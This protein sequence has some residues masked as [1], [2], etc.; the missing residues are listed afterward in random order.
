MAERRENFINNQPRD[1][2]KQQP[3][4]FNPEDP[5]KLRGRNQNNPN[6]TEDL[7]IM[8]EKRELEQLKKYKYPS[9][10]IE[11]IEDTPPKLSLEERTKEPPNLVYDLTPKKRGALAHS[12][13]AISQP[14]TST[15]ENPNK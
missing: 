12:L 15:K 7:K 13:R 14:E 5:L 2:F 6:L 4:S 9:L 10:W 1:S 11:C 8:K 3:A